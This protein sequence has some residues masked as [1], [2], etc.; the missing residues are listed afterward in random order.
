MNERVFSQSP[1]RLRFEERVKR[2]E[3]DRVIDLCLKGK[4]IK[5]L[6]DIGTGSGLFAEA[7]SK[8][9]LTVTG[10]DINPEM[11][12]TAEEY[13]PDCKF[14][15]APAENIPFDD[16][17]F[18]STFFGLVFHEVTDYK[19]SL[20]EAYRVS[21][22]FTFILELQYKE[23]DFGPPLKH[24]LKPEFIQ[25]ISVSTGY[26]KFTPIL[27]KNSVLYILEK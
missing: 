6:L 14:A 17:T 21:R 3:V 18:D 25:N 8:I 9:G 20:Q 26:K 11:I 22:Y 13:L 4:T 1:D 27:L 2:L 23:E 19:K 24:R 12:K 15:V 7:F 5:T 10:I 16:E